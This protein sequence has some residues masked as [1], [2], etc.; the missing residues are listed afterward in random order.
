M[1]ESESRN[2]VIPEPTDRILFCLPFF[3]LPFFGFGLFGLELCAGLGLGLGLTF[4]GFLGGFF[5]LVFSIVNLIF[6]FF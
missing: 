3:G 1:D 2:I 5:A 4:L 6:Y